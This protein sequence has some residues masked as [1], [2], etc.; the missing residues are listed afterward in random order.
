[1]ACGWASRRLRGGS[2]GRVCVCVCQCGREGVGVRGP[3]RGRL[4]GGAAAGKRASCATSSPLQCVLQHLGG[5]GHVPLPVLWLV[6]VVCVHVLVRRI[7]V[8]IKR[9]QQ[10]SN[11]ARLLAKWQQLPRSFTPTL[12]VGSA[13]STSHCKTAAARG[14]SVCT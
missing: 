1:M 8:E 7:E 6:V 13:R 9:K 12:R 2:G 11:I 14:F 4:L 3:S 5:L 10:A